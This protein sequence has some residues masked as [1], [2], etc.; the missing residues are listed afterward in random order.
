ML[1]HYPL[2]VEQAMQT[3]FRSLNERQRRLYAAVEARKLG[4]GG[5]TYLSHLFDCDRKTIRRGLQEL[6][7]PSPLPP[8]RARKKGADVALV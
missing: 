8:Q 4:R 2:A 3:T 7:Q 1:A 6:R 5:V